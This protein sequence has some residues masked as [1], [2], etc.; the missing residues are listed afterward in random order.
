[1]PEV[2]RR[3]VALLKAAIAAGST[4]DAD[5][6]ALVDHQIIANAFVE[7]LRSFRIFDRMLPS[8]IR[9]PLKTRVVANTVTF[10]GDN[11]NEAE[12]KPVSML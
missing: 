2:S 3:V 10:I 9:V 6:V 8:M 12:P 5:Y 4:S 11:V 1:M 7:S